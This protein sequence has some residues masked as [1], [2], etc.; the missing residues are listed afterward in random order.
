MGA[1]QLMMTYGSSSTVGHPSF[2]DIVSNVLLSDS[3]VRAV[4]NETLRVF[5]PVPA[6]TRSVR[7]APV[8]IPVS[9][10]GEKDSRPL[11]MPA[12]SPVAYFPI[13]IHKRKELW[14][15]DADVYDPNRWLNDG[16][17]RLDRVVKNPFMFIPFHAGPRIVNKPI[18]IHS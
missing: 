4:L 1:H 8:S 7:G 10:P 11:F 14:G 2:R 6:N 9:T 3:V 15:S 12:K 13:L 17:G 5:S 16:T 18:D